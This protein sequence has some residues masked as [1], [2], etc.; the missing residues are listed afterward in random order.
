MIEIEEIYRHKVF[1][2][3]E[4]QGKRQDNNTQADSKIELLI[5]SR[6]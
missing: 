4:P 3:L 1:D 6:Y 5:E 2:K